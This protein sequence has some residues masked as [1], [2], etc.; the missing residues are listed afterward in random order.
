MLEPLP[1]ECPQEKDGAGQRVG[2]R[3]V[4]IG[5][6]A[7]G[8]I[9]ASL[10]SPAVVREDTSRM[11]DRSDFPAEA[12]DKPDP[13]PDGLFYSAPRFVTH[14]DANAIAA[15][16]AL[17]RRVLPRNGVVL[18]LMS[19][20]VSHLPAEEN[21]A[22]VIGHGMNADELAANPRL[23]RWFVQDLNVEPALPLDSGTVDAATLCV[24]IQYLQQPLAVLRDVRRVLRPGGCLVV[25][26]SNRCFPTKAV[27]IWSAISHADHARLVQL[28]ARRAGFDAVE[29]FDL[30][31]EGH[32]SDPL[33]AVV[34][35]VS[36]A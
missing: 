9:A 1:H 16:T 17:Y 5:R 3:V 32:G 35:R 18:D 28:Y 11:T 22:A 12:F 19:S 8:V 2:E 29:G 23:T 34:C 4:A 14:I 7:F 10:F 21:Y 31:P 6:D 24:S 30:V 27:A 15:V 13:T 36:E 25:T 20:W 26:F 33:H